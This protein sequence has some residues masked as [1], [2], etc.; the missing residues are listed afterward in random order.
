MPPTAMGQA[1]LATF[2]PYLLYAFRRNWVDRKF[3]RQTAFLPPIVKYF[4]NRSS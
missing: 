3:A 4:T 2:G 1:L